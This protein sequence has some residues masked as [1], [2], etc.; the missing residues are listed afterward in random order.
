MRSCPIIGTTTFS[1]ISNLL[2]IIFLFSL[3]VSGYNGRLRTGS[4]L[5]FK[6]HYYNLSPEVSLALLFD[7]QLSHVFIFCFV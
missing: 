1:T 5:C 6:N 7:S 3:S 2:Y 4:N